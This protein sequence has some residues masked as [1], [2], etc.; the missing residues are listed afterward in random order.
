MTAPTALDLPQA[1]PLDDDI[2]AYF[3]IGR[4]RTVEQ[5][6][7]LLFDKLVETAVRSMSPAINDPVTAMLCLD[8]LAEGLRLLGNRNGLGRQQSAAKDSAGQKSNV[9]ANCHGTPVPGRSTK[10]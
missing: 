9:L 6:V 1:D 3:D 5:D 10:N 4:A 8:R 7:K 2:R